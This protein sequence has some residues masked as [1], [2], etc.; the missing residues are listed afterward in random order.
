MAKTQQF[1]MSSDYKP[2]WMSVK[3]LSLWGG[4]R[5]PNVAMSRHDH[6][7]CE[8]RDQHT[9]CV[10]DDRSLHHTSSERVSTKNDRTDITRAH[11]LTT[12]SN[13]N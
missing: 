12:F 11:I 4:G 1:D 13:R 10:P 9:F 7:W 8:L 6:Q 3:M 2:I 5:G